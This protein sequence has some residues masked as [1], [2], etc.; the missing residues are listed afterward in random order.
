MTEVAQ[1]Y[2]GNYLKDVDL[3]LKVDRAVVN[4]Q[5]LEVSLSQDDNAKSRIYVQS[6]NG[7]T[8]GIIKDRHQVLSEGDVFETNN[9]QLLLI[10]LSAQPLIVLSFSTSQPGYELDLI[11][12]GHT[13]GNHHYPIVVAEDKIYVQV[14][15][16]RTVIEA[17]IQNFKIPNLVIGY[18]LR[19]SHQS[20][21][22]EKASHQ[23]LHT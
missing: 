11:H 2:L 8:I 16:D 10:H 14:V 5:C 19:S 18:E 4:Q 17:T 1:V 13:L 20:I 9:D 21:V 15:A 7:Q 3:K 22:F 6:N 23:H 12:L